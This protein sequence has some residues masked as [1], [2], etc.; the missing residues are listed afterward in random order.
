VNSNAWQHPSSCAPMPSHDDSWKPDANESFQR[1]VKIVAA[2]ATEAAAAAAAAV[3]S[4][5]GIKIR[6]QM[7]ALRA[8]SSQMPTATGR[9]SEGDGRSMVRA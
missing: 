9:H 2:A 7:D 8:D 6:E 4:A 1:A 5:A 3:V